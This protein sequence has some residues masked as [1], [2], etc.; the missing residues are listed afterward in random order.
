MSCM[1]FSIELC[2][3][4]F[5]DSTL[6]MSAMGT[7]VASML[8]ALLGWNKKVR[9]TEIV[10]IRVSPQSQHLCRQQWILC[11]LTARLAQRGLCSA[12]APA[13]QVRLLLWKLHSKLRAGCIA[14]LGHPQQLLRTF[15]HLS[16]CVFPCE[17][18]H[19]AACVLRSLKRQ[20]P[21]M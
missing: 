6:L 9:Q 8:S 10:H 11:A 17:T 20:G 16:L 3:P 1:T 15:M 14:R 7:W 21:T 5:E 19:Q 2:L 18:I 4:S 12:S 13:G